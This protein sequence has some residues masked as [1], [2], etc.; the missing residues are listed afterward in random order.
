MSSKLR[1]E[2]Q[3]STIHNV[4]ETRGVAE[5]EAPSMS[6]DDVLDVFRSALVGMGY[7]AALAEM[8]RIGG[9]E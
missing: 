3:E 6:I 8:L 5:C 2:W 9:D 7:S 4:G 1:I